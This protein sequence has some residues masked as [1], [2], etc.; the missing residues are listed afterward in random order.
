M[1]YNPTVE[2]KS[3]NVERAAPPTFGFEAQIAGYSVGYTASDSLDITVEQAG[4]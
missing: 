2:V 1:T 3:N 4:Q